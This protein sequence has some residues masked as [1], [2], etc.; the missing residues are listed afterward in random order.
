MAVHNLAALVLDLGA[1]TM[2]ATTELLRDV[3]RE[4]GVEVAGVEVAEP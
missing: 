1:S 4:A 3:S 2:P